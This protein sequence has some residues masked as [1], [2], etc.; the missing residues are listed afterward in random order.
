MVDLFPENPNY[1]TSLSEQA[2]SQLRQQEAVGHICS[3]G[4]HLLELIN[5]VLDLARVEAGGLELHSERVEL[6]PLVEEVMTL[7][8]AGAAARQIAIVPACVPGMAVWADRV[9]LRQVL[10]NLLSNAVKYNREGGR[11]ELSSRRM[12]NKLR[13]TVADTGPGIP[14]D[15]L[16]RL[17]QPFQRLGLHRSRV[18]GTGIGLVVCKR[19]VE[20]ME[21]R[22]GCDSETGIGSRFWLELPLALRQGSGAAD[23]ASG[24]DEPVPGQLGLQG[25]VLYVEDNPVNVTV[26]QHLFQRLPGVQLLTAPDGETALALLQSQQLDLAL[27]DI[28]LPGMSGIELLQAMRAEPR[29]AEVP[30]IAVSAVAMPADVQAGMDAGFLAYV[31]KPFDLQDLLAHIRSVLA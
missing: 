29:T 5:E 15:Q 24:A 28:D 10:L 26:M 19:L 12:G 31:T 17:F 27:V 14:E 23:V 25:R 1:L 30:A 11:V 2:M 9:R 20:A 21:G 6:R 18:E 3:G 7:S 22:I 16:E 4:R 13:L 8:M